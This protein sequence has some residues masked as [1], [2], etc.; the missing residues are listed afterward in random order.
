MASEVQALGEDL[1]E[2]E[3]RG[4]L[5]IQQEVRD[6]L[7]TNELQEVQR[8][9][10]NMGFDA[11][12]E[13]GEEETSSA[14]QSTYVSFKNPEHPEQDLDEDKA[15]LH[16]QEYFDSIQD[17]R[18]EVGADINVIFGEFAAGA[19]EAAEGDSERLE[20]LFNELSE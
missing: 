4:W 5:K 11:F 18:D 8:G 17:I 2:K 13:E 19:V 16:K 10:S 15:H 14:P 1:P 20:E 12:K 7:Y 3:L 6:W 9:S